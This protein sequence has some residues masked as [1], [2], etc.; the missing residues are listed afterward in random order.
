MPH[1]RDAFIID[2]HIYTM[3]TKPAICGT[4]F[5]RRWAIPRFTELLECIV[6]FQGVLILMLA[7]TYRYMAV[8]GQQVP[9]ALLYSLE[10]MVGVLCGAKAAV[11]TTHHGQEYLQ[12]GG[13]ERQQGK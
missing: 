1:I 8:T 13:L 3:L 4:I 6:I 5:P 2:I 9:D 7:R 10:T 11:N 12:H